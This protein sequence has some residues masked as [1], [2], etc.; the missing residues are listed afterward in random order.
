M[1][2]KR[3]FI[4]HRCL[5]ANLVSFQRYSVNRMQC[6]CQRS[7]LLTYLLILHILVLQIPGHPPDSEFKLHESPVIVESNGKRVQV[8]DVERRSY[9]SVRWRPWFGEYFKF[10]NG[11][12]I[13]LLALP[14]NIASKFI[15]VLVNV[16]VTDTISWRGHRVMQLNWLFLWH[17][18]DDTT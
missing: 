17:M 18:P 2:P 1:K 12:Y 6:I 5:A 7:L 3:A 15:F 11:T 14:I 10:S 4:M 8:S 16:K 9:F 13:C